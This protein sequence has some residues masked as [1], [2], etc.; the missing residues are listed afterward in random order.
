MREIT[1]SK[2]NVTEF[3]TFLKS[4]EAEYHHGFVMKKDK[5]Y[6][7]A[8]T[9]IKSFVKFTQVDTDIIAPELPEDMPDVLKLPF[10]SMKKAIAALDVYK[11]RKVDSL[12]LKIDY[13]DLPDEN[14]A[15]RLKFRHK[16]GN[17]TIPCAESSFIQWPADEQW[18][19]FVDDK[20]IIC[21]ASIS[22]SEIKDLQKLCGLV[23][24]QTSDS[25]IQLLLECDSS[26]MSISDAQGDYFQ[27]P[28]TTDFSSKSE[29]KVS[30]YFTSALVKLAKSSH[31]EVIIKMFNKQGAVIFRHSDN[32]ILVIPLMPK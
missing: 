3:V 29:D 21:T 15:L 27:L 6:V 19:K 23:S 25:H 11:G 30:S 5:T 10:A 12:T 24:N 22:E 32:N 20:N 4:A 7:R 1:L 26:G 17:I 13:A 2:F 16:T 31:Y 14:V 9:K 8:T 28:I 18:G